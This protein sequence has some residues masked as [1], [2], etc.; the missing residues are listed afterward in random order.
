MRSS[1]LLHT[2]AQNVLPSFSVNVPK[3]MPSLPV[4]DSRGGH[5]FQR[6]NTS[7]SPPTQ[8][9]QPPT[10]H[11]SITAWFL[12]TSSALAATHKLTSIPSLAFVHIPTTL[13]ST[14]THNATNTNTT[15][16]GPSPIHEPGFADEPYFIPQSD[17]LAFVDA[18][19]SV[20][21]MR[22]VFSGHQHGNDWCMGTRKR[23]SVAGG[24]S[25]THKQQD[26]FF[27]CFGRHTGYGGYGS[28]ERGAWVVSVGL[29]GEG[30]IE[31]WIR[32][33][34]GGVSGHVV[35]NESYGE[36]VYGPIERTF[37]HLDDLKGEGESKGEVEVE[38]T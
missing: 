26:P 4:F 32:L 1:P 30:G 21:G 24:E 35:L 7:T 16:P 2:L 10:N 8:L 22:A 23:E 11:P 34:R 25:G 28:W 36:D 38:G 13:L 20:K 6:L 33:E 15:H 17:D 31:T 18:L 27:A 12:N 5:A 29:D 9:P 37:T 14:F 3:L 19:L